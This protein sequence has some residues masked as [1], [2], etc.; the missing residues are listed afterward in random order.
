MSSQITSFDS[1]IIGQEDKTNTYELDISNDTELLTLLNNNNLKVEILYDNNGVEQKI[2]YKNISNNKNN[3]IIITYEDK[4]IEVNGVKGDKQLNILTTG[5]TIPSNNVVKIKL[6]DNNN[7]HLRDEIIGENDDI[8]FLLKEFNIQHNTATSKDWN[9]ELP[10]NALLELTGSEVAG[11]IE[12]Y[13]NYKLLGNLTLQ[14]QRKM[15]V[16]KKSQPRTNKFMLKYKNNGQVPNFII[17]CTETDSTDNYLQIDNT[18]D[19]LPQEGTGKIS[20]RFNKNI[21]YV[22]SVILNFIDDNNN[23]SKYIVGFNNNEIEDFYFPKN[24]LNAS[25]KNYRNRNNKKD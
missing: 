13:E 23:S 19:I 1:S 2:F 24:K 22:D 11:T 15:I 12:V 4:N 21:Q 5:S 7:N 20:L 14:N 10:K 9:C 18:A 25:P 16:I 3:K 6:F 8:Y 17:K